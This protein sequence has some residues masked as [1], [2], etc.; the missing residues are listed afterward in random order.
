MAVKLIKVRET[1]KAS[2]CWLE[3]SRGWRASAALVRIAHDYGMTLTEDDLAILDAYEDGTTDSLTLSTGETVDPAECV[4]GQ[5]EMADQ[6]EE[7]LNDHV[8]PAGY[9][10]GWH[11]GEF[12]LWSDDQWEDES[13]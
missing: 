2:G 10:F 9:M 1:P 5:G 6:A 8:A 7:W 3:G 11:D 4:I 13:Y 12:F